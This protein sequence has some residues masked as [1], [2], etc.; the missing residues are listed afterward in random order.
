M[1][2]HPRVPGHPGGPGHLC[3]GV[4]PAFKED[5]PWCKDPGSPQGPL[6]AQGSVWVL[7]A[8]GSVLVSA[9]VLGQRLGYC[10]AEPHPAGGWLCRVVHRWAGSPSAG[11]S[12]E[13]VANRSSAS[14][15]SKPSFSCSPWPQGEENVSLASPLL[16]AK[17]KDK[18]QNQGQ[19]HPR[20]ICWLRWLV[21]RGSGHERA[22]SSHTSCLEIAGLQPGVWACS[23]GCGRSALLVRRAGAGFSKL[24]NDERRRDFGAGGA[25][26]AFAVAP[27]YA[28]RR[29]KS[30]LSR[31]GC[32][33][34][35]SFADF[36]VVSRGLSL[37]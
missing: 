25:L 26:R 13:K 28:D 32:P 12:L 29:G 30:L 8:L 36:T 20:Q 27:P 9:C 34:R 2:P 35:V 31:Q 7:E 15:L 23:A 4:K 19:Y 22:A 21:C 33:A 17:I 11:R 37:R 3:P 14:L 16:D 10:W 1:N 18:K 24:R 5:R 6:G